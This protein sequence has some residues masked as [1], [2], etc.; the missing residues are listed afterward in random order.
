MLA[1]LNLSSCSN[2]DTL[3]VLET[4]GSNLAILKTRYTQIKTLSPLAA[5]SKL[6]ELDIGATMVDSLQ[7]LESCLSLE[8]LKFDSTEVDSLDSLSSHPVL[9]R[10]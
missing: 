6:R 4:C 5:C 10:V 8:T 2:L 1:E 3:Q 7:P 9:H